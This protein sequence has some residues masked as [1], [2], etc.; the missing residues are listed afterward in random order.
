MM[1][2]EMNL[3]AEIGEYAIACSGCS[4]PYSK[5]I[6]IM[7]KQIAK[8]LSSFEQQAINPKQLM[9]LKGG[10]DTPPADPNENGVIG[11]EDIIGL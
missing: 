10:E 1:E 3:H 4:F 5:I 8:Q 2:R 6:C 7:E 9:Q 11:T